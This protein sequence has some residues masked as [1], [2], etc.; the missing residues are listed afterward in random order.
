MLFRS[1]GVTAQ[2][3][4][5]YEHAA[6]AIDHSLRVGPHGLPP[7][8][9][10]DWNDGMNRVG[11]EGRGESVWMG[12]FLCHV[13]DQTLPLAEAQGDEVRVARW[14]S[15]R[16]AWVAALES[17]GWDGAWYRRAYFDD[18]SPLGS[19]VNTEA[20]IDLIAQAWAV[21]SGAGDAQR[22]AQAMDSAQ[23]LLMDPPGEVIRLLDPP[24]QHAL[25]DAGYIQAYPR[26]V[27]ENGGQYN[28]AAVWALMALAR[29]GRHGAAW[30][31]FRRLSPAHRAGDEGGILRYGIEPYVMAGDVYTQAPYIGRG[32]WSWYS[33]S[34]GWLLRAGIESVC[35]VVEAQ[36]RLTVTP[37]LPPHWPQARVTLRHG[38]GEVHVVVC[39]DTA[40][41]QPGDLPADAPVRGLRPGQAITLAGLPDQTVLLVPASPT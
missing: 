27:R 1:P 37:C 31:A 24:L 30:E 5:L 9:T 2:T 25:P 36:G 29:L 40:R 4:S 38:G 41:W 15:A 7:I 23:A 10:G 16:Q 35:G 17:A 21:L 13:V 28:H 3:A 22:A 33:G 12:W 26:G 19:A 20:R 14:R 39:Q 8:G 34:A 32:G 18:G 6:R 11:H